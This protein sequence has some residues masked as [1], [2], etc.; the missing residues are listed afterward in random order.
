ML[1]LAWHRGRIVPTEAIPHQPADDPTPIAGAFTTTRTWIETGRLAFWNR[2]VA[3][4][5]STLASLGLASHSFVMPTEADLLGLAEALGGEDVTIRLNAAADGEVWAIARPLRGVNE[6]I[7]LG[8]RPGTVRPEADRS[9]RKAFR[10]TWRHSDLAEIRR[11]EVDE[12]VL[13]A[14]DGSVLETSRGNLFVRRREWDD[15]GW[16]TPPLDGRLLPGVA[17]AVIMERFGIVER[18]IARSDLQSSITA[19]VANSVWGVREVLSV[20]GWPIGAHDAAIGLIAEELE[21][22]SKHGERADSVAAD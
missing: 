22:L 21:R 14:D 1:P 2:H 20:D 18:T 8:Y 15:E 10:Q 11:Q 5:R 3:R 19:F 12:L 6:P 9:D 4:L 16:V 17:R 7:V 13:W